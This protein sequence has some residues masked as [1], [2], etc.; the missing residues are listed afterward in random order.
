M[1]TPAG[2]HRHFAAELGDQLGVT[3]HRG[4]LPAVDRCPVCG[5]NSVLVVDADY[6]H[7]LWYRCRACKFSGHVI[8]LLAAARKLTIPQ[9][10]EKLINL[11]GQGNLRSLIGSREIAEYARDSSFVTGVKK[12][13]WE[14]SD[15]SHWT[16]PLGLEFLQELG[17]W[18]GV[19][20]WAATTG[21]LVSIS[22]FRD[23]REE[24]QKSHQCVDVYKGLPRGV[25]LVVIPWEDIP[26]RLCALQFVAS[27]RPQTTRS[28]GGREPGLFMLGEL[29]LQA[30]V[31]YAWED[32]LLAL[33]LRQ[34]LKL[35]GSS[36]HPMVC[37]R[38]G[39]AES[40]K[41]VRTRTTVFW[42]LAESM[43]LFNQARRAPGGLIATS[44][45]VDASAWRNPLRF[46]SAVRE[47]AQ[48]WYTCLR[49]RL[50]EMNNA[51]IR[52][53][54]SGLQLTTSE[55][56]LLLGD[57]GDVERDKIQHCMNDAGVERY[58]SLGDKW[59][60]RKEGG[61]Y[62]RRPTAANRHFADEL[63]TDA[64]LVIHTV[65]FD[66]PSGR[67]YFSGRVEC[68]GHP[69]DFEVEEALIRRNPPQY[70]RDLLSRAGLAYPRMST[71]SRSLDLVEIALAFHPPV[72]R[73]EGG[74]VG[75][76][77]ARKGFILPKMVITAEQITSE[78][79][80]YF[81]PDSLPALRAVPVQITPALI[82]SW[83][84]QHDICAAF[85]AAFA[86]AA[87]NMMAPPD[88]RSPVGI[89]LT[90]RRNTVAGMVFDALRKCLSGISVS[91][92]SGRKK[93]DMRAAMEELQ[94]SQAAH[95]VPVF[96]SY[97]E[98]RPDPLA[99][100]IEGRESRNA[101]LVA[102]TRLAF[103]LSVFGGWNYVVC[104]LSDEETPLPEFEGLLP[105]GLQV[106]LARR[107]H[108]DLAQATPQSYLGALKDWCMDASGYRREVVQWVFNRARVLL[109]QGSPS[110][111]F[112]RQD[113]FL[114]YL[115]RMLHEQ[116]A[117]V[118]TAGGRERA[119]L[120]M[121]EDA[122]VMWLDVGRLTGMAAKAGIPRLVDAG[123]VMDCLNNPEVCDMD[124]PRHSGV[125]IRLSYWSRRLD[126]WRTVHAPELLNAETRLM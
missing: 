34:G 42:S 7:S 121:D 108:N 24:V 12:L 2:I 51:D 111:P 104:P 122:G 74:R 119:P 72:T 120:V 107:S 25:P 103:Y 114:A 88:N 49:R 123:V 27:G 21:E 109:R 106:L 53:W 116:A 61:W 78:Q 4:S 37:W 23:I 22:T 113:R 76:D 71:K 3:A 33:G 13:L 68:G 54:L 41:Y 102:P 1:G 125:P 126:L 79:M 105:G 29:P 6:D 57:C 8:E 5:K 80:R 36:P 55:W 84:A 50:L 67:T 56:D 83:I 11:S 38:S 86:L 28:L 95:D 94:R 20:Q 117:T 98:G 92:P 58:V 30:D 66:E 73:R 47:A 39:S 31:V 60:V 16:D 44:P 35:A 81:S 77:P 14:G 48:P 43:E 18:P 96:V 64:M 101:V 124:L 17:L 32:P 10:V 91:L 85:W 115:F 52:C 15:P 89:C 99:T 19:A 93:A 90:G 87:F 118:Q 62:L 26:G 59:V 9:A 40:W 100:W 69:V 75:W 97:D 63:L 112:G 65:V 70:I 110:G 45:S 46:L 82:N